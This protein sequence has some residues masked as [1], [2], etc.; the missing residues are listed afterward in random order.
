VFIRATALHAAVLTVHA[1][2]TIPV[3]AAQA[4]S[5]RTAVIHTHRAS[6]NAT[7]ATAT[8]YPLTPEIPAFPTHLPQVPPSPDEIVIKRDQ[9]NA[10]FFRLQRLEG[11][12]TLQSPSSKALNR[13]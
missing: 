1:D 2:N 13:R 9:A 5:G 10:C 8:V 6:T 7:G 12:K 11:E 3:A 4:A